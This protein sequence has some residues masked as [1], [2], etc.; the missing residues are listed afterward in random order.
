M[1]DKIFMPLKD[2][3]CGVRQ[4]AIHDEQRALEMADAAEELRKIRSTSVCRAQISEE[5]VRDLEYIDVRGRHYNVVKRTL[6]VI[7][8]ALGLLVFLIPLVVILLVVY[9]DDP[10][11]VIF[12]QKRVGR[13]G[14]CFQMYKIRTMR[15]DTPK[16]VAQNDLR[17]RKR[18]VTRV[19]RVL[20]KLSLDEIP[21][22]FNVLRGDMSLVGPRPLIQ[23]E[24]DIHEMR[25]RFGVYNLRPGI[26]GLAQINGRGALSPVEKV[27]WD[28]KYL[29]NFGFKEDVRVLSITLPKVIG[30]IFPRKKRRRRDWMPDDGKAN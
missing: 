19:G 6:D 14:N 25:S 30:V 8:S 27:R 1:F 12:S 17:N 11:K 16:Y 9:I 21:Q 10:G 2:G 5:D 29:E 15:M 26:T 24:A 23:N 22:L 3:D 13:N 28:V 18:H 4:E 20:R 7:F